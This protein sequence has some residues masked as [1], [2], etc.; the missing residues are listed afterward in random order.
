MVMKKDM[1]I[2]ALDS[3]ASDVQRT[4][5][6][7]PPIAL[8]WK[9]GDNWSL[10]E[11]FVHLQTVQEMFSRRFHR[12][13]DEDDPAIIGENPVNDPNRIAPEII[14]QWQTARSELCAWLSELPPGAWNRH[15]EH[16]ERGRI[17][18]R[19]EAQVLIDHDTEHLNQI[20][21]IR[22]AWESRDKAHD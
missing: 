9:H 16:N 5:K 3:T 15:G 21:D 20:M 6:P 14:G 11:V 13:A 8:T 18:L 22:R 12:L 19:S 1:V 2:E 17:T 10:V 4:L 7:L